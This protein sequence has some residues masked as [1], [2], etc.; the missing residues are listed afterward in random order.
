MYDV[1]N[2]PIPKEKREKIREMISDHFIAEIARELDV[3]K[4]TV[5]KY[6]ND[7]E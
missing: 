4:A 6:G 1:P 5:R 2:T 3:C 7:G